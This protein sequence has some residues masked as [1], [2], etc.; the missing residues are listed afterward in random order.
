MAPTTAP[1][2]VSTPP[3]STMTSAS[4]ESEMPR[5][6]GKT[7]PLRY[8]NSAPATPA[9]V[10]AI[11]KAVHWMG[12]PSRPTAQRPVARRPQREA[13]WREYDDPKCCDRK[14]GHADRKPVE[15][16]RARRPLL[17]PDAEDAV[18][19]AGHRDPLER[20]RPDDLRKRQR[21]HREIDAGELNRKESEHRRACK[22][23]QRAK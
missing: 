13:K 20:D 16:R 23:Q 12:S 19:A 8:A 11:T 1:E 18:V 3:S 22:T 5:L 17:G 6:S 2:T 21:Q 9:T 10:P 4:T 15:I 7:L 14:R